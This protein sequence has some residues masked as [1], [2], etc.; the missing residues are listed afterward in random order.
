MAYLQQP[1]GGAFASLWNDGNELRYV[2]SRG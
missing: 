2:I 1:K